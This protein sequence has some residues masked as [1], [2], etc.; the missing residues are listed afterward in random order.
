MATPEQI[1]KVLISLDEIRACRQCDTRLRWGDLE[2]P[3]CG[4]DLDEALRQWAQRLVDDLA[5]ISKP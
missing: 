4:A 2:C 1:A 3:H 5:H